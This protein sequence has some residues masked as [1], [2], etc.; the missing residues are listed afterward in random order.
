MVPS[1]N[2]NGA[3]FRGAGAYH[4][5]DKA[6]EG[7]PK[8]S[9]SSRVPWTA[10]RNLVNEDPE[11]AIDEMW[12]T[13][14]L[15][16][17]LKR[18]SGHDQRGRKN[19]N[20]VKTLSLAWAPHQSP[21]RGQMEAAADSFL[22]SMG[23]QEC[24]ALLIPHNDEPHPHLHIILNRVHPETGLTLNDWQ[25]RKRAQRWALEWEKDEGQILCLA[26]V[27]KYEKGID[28]APNGMP[29]PHAKLMEERERG[30]HSDLAAAAVLDLLEKDLLAKR[31]KEERE[32]FLASGKAQFRAIRQAAYREVRDEF[33]PHWRE[34]FA[35]DKDVRDQ[36][37][38]DT[39]RVHLDAVRLAR[40]GDHQGATLLLA[41]FDEQRSAALD[42]LS[43]DRRE[44]REHQLEATRERQDEACRGLIAQRGIDFQEI[45]DRQKDE[46]AEYREL[47]AQREAAQPYD[48]DR[49]R[50]LLAQDAPPVLANDN[51]AANELSEPANQNQ[52]D[53]EAVPDAPNPFLQSARELFPLGDTQEKAPHR[54]AADLAAGGI[55][56][57]IEI[58]LRVM[59]GF[60]SP[61][62]PKEQAAAKARAIR[63]EQDAPARAA[64]LQEHKAADDFARVAVAAAREAESER[65]VERQLYWEERGRS[66]SRER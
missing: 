64:V 32:A 19:D 6:Q 26:R 4:L 20:P 43:A 39:R 37:E 48:I 18:L 21:T 42:G 7:R 3:S 34:H 29:Y 33:K 22:Q 40:E 44:L 30:L 27:E 51:R 54:D 25:E 57:V 56:A 9:T 65:Q 41:A 15:A 52:R 11:K 59:E 58:G 17:H 5:H 13:A 63:D 28:L 62:S 60:I 45:K 50:Q 2:K 10:T 1:I 49:L 53:L 55:A 46:R 8:L 14:E 23:W 12:H 47:Q 24:Q 66:R 38:R 31:H 35:E 61:P 16:E 36:L